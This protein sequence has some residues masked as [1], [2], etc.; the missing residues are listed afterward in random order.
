[1]DVKRAIVHHLIKRDGEQKARIELSEKLLDI[2]E[3]ASELMKKLD[4]SYKK[5]SITYAVFN[6][7]DGRIFPKEFG[8]YIKSQTDAQFLEYSKKS[9]VNLRDQIENIAPAKGGFLVFSEYE[10]QYGRFVSVFL[11][12]DTVGMLFKRDTASSTF[13]ID[14]TKHLDL[15]KLA[16]ACR[17]NLNKYFS[18]N[19]KYLSFIKKKLSDISEYFI[20]WIAAIERESNKT[21]TQDFYELTNLVDCPA[22]DEG[23]SISRDLFRKQIYD[24]VNTSP[25]RRVNLMEL[26]KHFYDNEQYLLGFAEQHNIV[27]DTEFKPDARVMKKFIRIDIQSD[28]IHMRFSRGEL[29]TKVRFDKDNENVVI[30]ESEKFAN[31]LREEVSQN[32]EH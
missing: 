31:A 10:V 5:M 12:R 28:G 8:S 7:T 27:M 16:M 32:E 24:Y 3:M 29:K 15:D 22:D 4:G 1:M 9:A 23:Q 13:R 21:F 6:L 25:T 20:N 19:G 14:P 30:I 26:S 18:N 11:I 17:I 2:D